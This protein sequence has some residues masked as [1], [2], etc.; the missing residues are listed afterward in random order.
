MA[1]KAKKQ[2]RSEVTCCSGNKMLYVKGLAVLGVLAL[3]AGI[4]GAYGYSI[5]WYVLA[6]VLWIVAWAKN[7]YCCK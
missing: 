1:K 6:V 7:Q 3:I 4:Y 5:A 2:S